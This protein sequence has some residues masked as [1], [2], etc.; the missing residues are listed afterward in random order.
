MGSRKPFSRLSYDEFVAACIDANMSGRVN[1]AKAGQ[2][3]R[4]FDEM[5]AHAE[6]AV[7]R[8]RMATRKRNRQKRRTP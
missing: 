4:E 2:S 7:L 8:H 5:I 6:Q 3:G 1:P